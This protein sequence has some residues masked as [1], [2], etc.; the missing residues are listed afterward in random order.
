MKKLINNYKF[1]YFAQKPV[2]MG[3][4]KTFDFNGIPY[5]K[6]NVYIRNRF[7]YNELVQI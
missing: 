5:V 6:K 3:K 7:R 4:V 1:F 2:I